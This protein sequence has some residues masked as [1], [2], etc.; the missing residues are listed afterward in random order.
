MSVAI[1][2]AEMGLAAAKVLGRPI[3]YAFMTECQQTETRGHG[4]VV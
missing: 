3:V 2:L 4:E 1:S